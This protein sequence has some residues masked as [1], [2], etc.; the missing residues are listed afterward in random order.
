MFM[1]K[2]IDSARSA[3]SRVRLATAARRAA[4]VV[5]PVERRVLLSAAVLTN[6]V[7]T[8]TGTSG[9]DTISVNFAWSG[10]GVGDQFRTTVNG[11]TQTFTAT[12]T[13]AVQSLVINAGDGDDTVTVKGT[14]QP[15]NGGAAL[16]ISVDGGS[17]NDS[18]LVQALA[19]GGA[20]YG[21]NV[22]AT[23][24][25]GNDG[26]TVY[27][28]G[29]ATISGGTGDDVLSASTEVG[30]TA[31]MNGGDGNDTL[32]VLQATNGE[33]YGQMNGGAG[34][35]YFASYDMGFDLS[36]SGGDGI[37]T[38][39][40]T[41]IADGTSYT[42]PADV[43]N[44]NLD[45]GTAKAVIGNGLDNV[46]TVP[47]G[48]VSV[49]GG[50]GNDTITEAGAGGLLEGDS[51]NDTLV[52]TGGQDT[53]IG[54]AGTDTADF[55]TV[56]D[57]LS[58][59]LDGSKPSGTA[60]QIA[61]GDG[62]AFDSSTEVVLGGSGADLLV[63]AP[64]GGDQLDGNAGND[65]LV[66]QGGADAIYGGDGDDTINA[67]DGGAT[68]IDG[69]AGT[70]T[71]T[72]DATGDTTVNV[73][74]VITTGGGPAAVLS[75]GV[76]TVTGTAGADTISVN[77]SLDSGTNY[78]ATVTVDGVTQ[79]F[80]FVPLSQIVVNAGDGND[81]ITAS[82]GQ[83]NAALSM[84]VNAGAGD[85]SVGFNS[86]ALAT[87][88]GGDGNDTL[89][90]GDNYG[91]GTFVLSGDA[92]DDTLSAN[93]NYAST[94]TALYGGDGNDTLVNDDLLDTT[95]LVSGGA[96]TD[97]YDVYNPGGVSSR[98]FDMNAAVT[99]VPAS[100]PAGIESDVENLNVE[101]GSY[102]GGIYVFGN[103]AD[104]VI[105]VNIAGG[106]T[107]EGEGGDDTITANGTGSVG[108]YGDAGN[109]TLLGSS[110]GGNVLYSGG[111]G[112]DRVD[113]SSYTDPLT[114]YLSGLQASG[115][116][117]QIA[118]GGAM[119]FDGTVEQVYG[120][121]G[122]DLIIA[123]PSGGDSLYGNGGND[124]LTAQG[125]VDALYGGAGDDTLNARD[126]GPTTVDGGDG[127]DTA[128]IDAA[129]DTTANVETIYPGTPTPTSTPPVRL[130]G[131]TGGTAGSYQN[132]G[133]TVAMATDGNFNTFF[134]GPTPDGNVVT[135]DLGSAKT[136]SQIGYAPRPGWADRMVDGVFQ[137]S[138]T[139]D[140]SSGVVNV[141]EVPQA[142]VAGG[143]T[144][145]TIASNT[146]YR[147][148][149]Y[150]SPLSSYG[151]IAEFEL[152][153]PGTTTTPTPT[154]TQ[155]KGATTG[156]AGSY[157]NS[158]NTVAKATDGDLTTYF[159]G[160]TANGDTV[161]VDLGAPTVVT[162]IKY[163]PRSGWA[164]RMVGGIFQASNTA[165][166]SSGVVNVYTVTA[167]PTVGVL[168]TITPAT[169]AAYR[170]WR[171]VAP[172]G[173]YGNI[174][175]FQLFGTP[176]TSPTQ[177][178]GTTTGTA[179]S[180]TNDGNT[181]AK[182]TD[183]NLNTYFD[184]PTA[185]G[186]T[187][188]ID[189]GAAQS[190]AQIKYAP[191]AGFT[192]R[193]VG[194]VFQASNSADFSSGVVNVYTVTAAPTAGVLTAV[195]TNTTTPYRY[196]RYVAPNNSYGNIAEFQLFGTATTT[197]PTPT[198]RTGTTFGTAG[199]FQGKGYTIANATDGNVATYFDGPT[200][201]GDVVGLDL[202]SAQSVSTI[203]YAPR[204]GWESRMVGGVFQA[205]NTADFSSGVVNLY[206]VTA[207][208]VAGKLTTVTLASPVTDRYYRYVAPAN[209]YGD[210]AEFQ[211]FG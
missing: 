177:L 190:V 113:L 170:Y 144:T 101:G 90:G 99:A 151:N 7:L 158:G 51:G 112:T 38:V 56:T 27:A 189:L 82:T 179:G 84:L 49:Y 128:Y 29:N 14:V 172:N 194:G 210:I 154:P 30:L 205:S 145:V 62:D 88:Y 9:A 111:D 107:A 155:L 156:T 176:A 52:G 115:T 161:V 178:T 141:Y 135:I 164:A 186:D 31:I 22:S 118:T 47:G 169:T 20:G 117:A 91:D 208:P 34:N 54:G 109:D 142:P 124:T 171:Y 40:G 43:E 188:V 69:G 153:A 28:D 32:D 53:F 148:W 165:D 3:T 136:V 59:Y 131:T 146:P 187:V 66:A 133:N 137:A 121:S 44:F 61:A 206:T 98:T 125:G 65:T 211:L 110:G 138:N 63:A 2:R 126:G 134:N 17:G 130:T 184:G 33:V 6:G 200:A 196:W 1:H 71:A 79:T 89:G 122:N 68:Y 80:S 36:I 180:Y 106:I 67:A 160:P 92:G 96:G 159:D 201:S 168:T 183:G 132:D 174:A 147:Y 35:D 191:R 55:S 24:D 13:S 166:F 157:A 100:G 163:A 83:V 207:A 60:A 58:I 75:N 73:E 197:T 204:V 21:A 114:L 5:E 116:A 95:L 93:N 16:P 81:T 195:A 104:N 94:Q 103:G 175:E 140:F 199:S 203:S 162:Q 77:A 123:A 64:N 185:N 85:D 108:L 72:I 70:D 181:V 48:G 78:D 18:I 198:Q 50:A 127:T 4:P 57:P 46:I 152:F 209:S 173:S 193:M 15:P 11:V 74:N 37:D 149:R 139:A 76:L 143:L 8:V 202:G 42:L 87:V 41:W 182:A 86:D 25:D 167:T 105:A 150:A 23:G 12:P 119:E 192:S 129:G 39:D 120:G 10:G 19:I 45:Q 97:T 102:P 26:I